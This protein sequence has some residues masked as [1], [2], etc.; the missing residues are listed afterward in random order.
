MPST[1]NEFVS[2]AVHYP[3]GFWERHVERWGKMRARADATSEKSYLTLLHDPGPSRRWQAAAGLRRHHL[4]SA[5]A[6]TALIEALADPEPI[7][8]WQAAEALA[9][10]DASH[11]FPAVNTTLAA[12]D[13]LR[14]AGAAEALGLM[15]G[16]AAAQALVKHLD[17]PEPHVRAAVATALGRIAD[18]TKAP[19]LLP[20][21][22]DDEPDVVRAAARALGGICD[23]CAA[24]PLAEALMHA[25][26]P[27][28][29]RR[30]LAAALARAPHPDAQ[31]ALLQALGDPDPQVRGYAA[32]ALGH[33]GNEAAHDALAALRSDKAALLKGTVGDVAARA[34]TLLERRGRRAAPRL[35]TPTE[36]A[37]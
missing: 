22:A 30:A 3:R 4:R 7:V 37:A 8:R 33:V 28:L 18:P 2:R 1:F 10:Q 27:L 21:L 26:Q 14:R 24:V 16:E 19:A 13:P 9:V 5:E 12:A 15:G 20:L 23:A 11:A 29:V 17:D 36:P 32:E 6:I 35:P 34:L 31:P 25:D